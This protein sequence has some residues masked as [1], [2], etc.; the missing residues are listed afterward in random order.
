MP[1]LGSM[2]LDW[3][4]LKRANAAT[5]EIEAGVQFLLTISEDTSG[6]FLLPETLDEMAAKTEALAKIIDSQYVVAYTPKR[7][8]KDSPKGE[9][10]QI[11]VR[12]KRE[13]MQ[14]ESHR[15]LIVDK[16]Q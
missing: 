15:K 2:T 9:V 1:R 3:E 7:T 11:E 5:K 6:L 10:R 8:L 16:K 4:R 14:V 12:S 13:G